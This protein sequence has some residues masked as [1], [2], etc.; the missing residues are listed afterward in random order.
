MMSVGWRIEEE[1]LDF[2]AGGSPRPLLSTWHYLRKTLRRRWRTWV[3]IAALGALLGMASVV[4]VPPTS[5]ATVTL[6]LAHPSG[7][8]PAQAMA[9]DVSFLNTREVATGV[10]HE[11][12]L[13][14][15]AKEFESEVVPE[16]ITDQVLRLTISAPTESEAVTRA[17]ALVKEYL[18]FRS[19]QLRSLSHGLVSGYRKRIVSLQHQVDILTGQY[20]TLSEEGAG[21]KSHASD[22]LAERTQLN[23]QITSMQ[24]AI[25]EA[26]LQTDAAVVS[27]HVIDPVQAVPFSAKRA[28]VLRVLSGGVLG[29][30]LGAGLVLFQALTSERVRRRQ[31]VALA[32]EVPVRYSVAWRGHGRAPRDWLPTRG[33][34]RGGT[35]RQRDLDI[36][37]HGLETAL[38]AGSPSSPGPRRGITGVS[39]GRNRTGLAL[40]ALGNAPVAALVV[41]ELALRL[42]QLG[43]SVFLVDLSERGEL[44][45]VAKRRGRESR[46]DGEEYATMMEV[47]RPAGSPALAVGPRLGA[48][49]SSLGGEHRAAWESA[50]VTLALVEVDPALDV[51]TLRTWTDQIVPLVTAG[52]STAELLQTVAELV[53][54]SGVA[55]PFAMMVGTDPTDESWG[56]TEAPPPGEQPAEQVQE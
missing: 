7:T 18:S 55:M 34:Q 29:L 22:I 14:I 15:S 23:S 31:E 26:T 32:L 53:R 56:M 19:E 40:A 20:N 43:R 11:L 10:I 51:S 35:P 9:T 1:D 2:D 44:A 48:P 46:T 28:A 6:L 45:E 17:R 3:G 8:D 42:A 33:R 49:G 54:S 50:D 5:S 25:E 52:T 13:G 47:V 36:L 27:T 41:S 21:G 39:G 16:T 38:S 37:A 12:A 4:L 24:Q 30:A